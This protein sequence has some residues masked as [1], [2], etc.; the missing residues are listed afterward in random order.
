VL[1]VALPRPSSD[2]VIRGDGRGASCAAFADEDDAPAK[3]LTRDEAEALRQRQP[4]LSPWRVV[5]AQAVLG[6]IVA[7]VAW[8]ASASEIVA[9]S[10]LYGA[11]VVALPGALMARGATSRLSSLSPL[12]GAV[13]MMGWEFAKMA[14]A[15]AML[16][17]APRIVPG[18]VWP[19]MLASL[20][21]CLQTYWLALLWR[22]RSA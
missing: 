15:V 18:L 1:K 19:A 6:A 9:L 3:A 7:I 16:V 17:L 14:M 4:T 13:S 22:G 12:I 8:A 11:A 21:V 10:A 20:A 5:L 2:A